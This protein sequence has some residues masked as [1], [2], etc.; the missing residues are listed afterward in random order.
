MSYL[1]DK[2]QAINVISIA[3]V[4]GGIIGVVFVIFEWVVNDVGGWLWNDLLN[5][6]SQRVLVIPIA[7]VMSVIYS[8]ALR[9]A[10]QKRVSKA[11][12]DLFS[13]DFTE[14]KPTNIKKIALLFGLGA[15]SLLAG[16]SLGP[17]A[18]LVAV[19]LAIGAWFAGA[20]NVLK[21]PPGQL[22]VLSAVGAL[23]SAFFASLIPIAIP[24]LM[25]LQKKSLGI[26]SGLAV[27]LSSLAA[28]VAVYIFR[29]RGYGSVPLSGN[30]EL[31][32]IL[33]AAIAGFVCVL[34][35]IGLKWLIKI[36]KIYVKLIDKK[37][38]WYNAAAIFGLVLGLLYLIGG[39]SVQFS[40]SEGSKILFEN[41]ASYG[42]AAL[43]GLVIVKLV[44]TSWSLASGYRGG[45]VFPSV[46][47][48]MALSLALSQGVA[49]LSEPGATIGAVSGVFVAL[50]SPIV[51]VTMLLALFPLKLFI[52]VLAGVFGAVMGNKT[53]SRL[54][55]VNNK[56]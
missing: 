47:M 16:A 18:S 45:V 20:L 32:D 1:Y 56:K 5:S 31:H 38:S 44:A 15:L 33:V 29:G 49:A 21:F 37:Y 48:G 2:N 7:V 11:E 50:T 19:S 54:E 51:G 26:I 41:Q 14:V 43:A 25:L 12:T 34:L 28:W 3:T 46:Y 40:G 30:F 22:L 23:L 24:L 42:V 9:S 10:G 27:I 53:F 35:G 6:D 39:Q 8:L 4:M 55:P 13:E 36:F 52:L 17:E